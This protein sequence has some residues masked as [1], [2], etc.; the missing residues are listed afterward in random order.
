MAGSSACPVPCSEVL[1][2]PPSYAQPGFT[3]YGLN[4]YNIDNQKVYSHWIRLRLLFYSHCPALFPS[5]THHVHRH[6]HTDTH[7]PLCIQCGYLVNRSLWQTGPLAPHMAGTMTT[8]LTDA[9]PRTCHGTAAQQVF[10]YQNVWL[11]GK[12]F[13]SMSREL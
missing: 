5:N 8:P 3:Q 1:A 12:Q 13:G 2:W 6:R 10:R 4:T 9:V 7:T 11:K